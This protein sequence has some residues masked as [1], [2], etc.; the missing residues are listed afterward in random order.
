MSRPGGPA[1]VPPVALLLS[2]DPP[3]SGTR[4]GAGGCEAIA[5]P[6]VN[7]GTANGDGP[8]GR[9]AA[10]LASGCATFPRLGG[11][12]Q[13]HWCWRLQRRC[14]N[15]RPRAW[16]QG[17]VR[18][19]GPL[20][21]KARLAAVRA[22]FRVARL[23][24]H[25]FALPC[26]RGGGQLGAAAW[27][28]LTRGPQTL[29]AAAP[30]AHSEGKVRVTSRFAWSLCLT[31]HSAT[32]LRPC[33]A[34]GHAR[35]AWA[36]YGR[37]SAV[38][39][40]VCPPRGPA[41]CATR[42]SERHKRQC[43]G[44]APRLRLPRQR[45]VAVGQSGVRCRRTCRAWRAQRGHNPSAGAPRAGLPRRQAGGL[46]RGSSGWCSVSAPAGSRRPRYPRPQDFSLG[47]RGL[48]L[49]SRGAR[50]HLHALGPGCPVGWRRNGNPR[51]RG[52]QGVRGGGGVGGSS[53]AGAEQPQLDRG[54]APLKRRQAAVL[55]GRQRAHCRLHGQP[56][57]YSV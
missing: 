24:M 19:A 20:R 5:A 22:S 3:L 29:D 37:G 39:L 14:C 23:I 15:T 36:A 26:R 45:G 48:S 53:G 13:L 47:R 6:A 16:R 1:E 25:R 43:C 40:C 51:G 33:I 18:C 49:G 52:R 32:A 17:R 56:P 54:Q 7:A 8:P 31:C 4:A 30:V 11:S 50:P 57:G 44:V 28:H 46:S 27:W 2:R 9:S 10:P 42:A 41:C 34:R 21:A 38:R 12:C 55:A 35:H